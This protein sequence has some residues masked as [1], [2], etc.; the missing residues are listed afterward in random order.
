MDEMTKH[1]LDDMQKAAAVLVEYTS[2]MADRA[3]SA[4][5]YAICL[6]HSVDRLARYLKDENLETA[7]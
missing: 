1:K 3:D 4:Y 2:D 5:H 7:A 6:M